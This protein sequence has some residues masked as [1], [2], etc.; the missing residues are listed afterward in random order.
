MFYQIVATA[1]DWSLI[2]LVL[3]GMLLCAVPLFLLLQITK[4]LRGFLPQVRRALRS[5]RARVVSVSAGIDRVLAGLRA[6]VLWVEGAKAR[7]SGF[8]RVWKSD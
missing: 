3:E 1:R 4:W 8:A 5:V 6:P 2:L 7:V